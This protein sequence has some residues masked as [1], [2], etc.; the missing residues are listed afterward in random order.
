MLKV[1]YIDSHYQRNTFEPRH[2]SKEIPM[3][4][5]SVSSENFVSENWVLKLLGKRL[6]SFGL[7]V[8]LLIIPSTITI[9]THGD[10][11]TC[12]KSVSRI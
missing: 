12:F 2:E 5:A 6:L 10:I 8:F 4:Y 7:N 3:I 11:L 1:L 9:F